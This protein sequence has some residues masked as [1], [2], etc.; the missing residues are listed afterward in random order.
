MIDYTHCRTTLI[1]E[2]MKHHVGKNPVHAYDMARVKPPTLGTGGLAWVYTNPVNKR[3]PGQGNVL[4]CEHRQ[5][6]PDGS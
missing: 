2:V 5:D 1:A 3:S 4:S 6:V